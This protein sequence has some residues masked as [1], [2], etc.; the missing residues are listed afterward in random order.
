MPGKRTPSSPPSFS[1]LKSQSAASATTKF[2][3]PSPTAL[4]AEPASADDQAVE[5]GLEPDLVSL[6]NEISRKLAADVKVAN[7][8]AAVQIVGGPNIVG[9]GFGYANPG[10]GNS[11][12][13]SA[14]PGQMG[15]VVFTHEKTETSA[16]EAEIHSIAGTRSLSSVPLTVIPVGVVEAASHRFRLRPAPGGISAGH[17]A[18]GA[19]TLGCLATRDDRLLILSNNHVLANVNAGSIGDPLLQPGPGDGGNQPGDIIALLERFIPINLNG[20]I[21]YVDCAT[22]WAYPEH[23]R[24]ELMYL[25]N[26]VPT[27]FRVGNSPISPAVNLMVGKTGRTTQLTQGYITAIGVAISVNY[28]GQLGHFQDQMSIVSSG[29]GLF[30]DRGDSGSLVWHWG[31]GYEPVGLLFAVGGTTTFANRITNVMSALAIQ[32]YT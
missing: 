2:S 12:P 14:G 19:G 24:P 5:A 10:L 17:F 29:G 1:D 8:Q 32:L 4:G 15:L 16:V 31:D 11:R 21:N 25:A 9:V 6:R 20:G 26:G 30:G 22:G 7:A 28:G 27:F 18:I 23:V 13:G 3:K